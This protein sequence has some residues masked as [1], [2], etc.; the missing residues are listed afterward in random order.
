MEQ[1]I[2]YLG[3]NNP[4]VVPEL[5]IWGIPISLYLFLGG[6]AAGIL[7]F[8]SVLYLRNRDEKQLYS[9]QR[10][11]MLASMALIIGVIA[12]LFD[13]HKI[14]NSWRLYTTFDLGA[15]M[16]WGAWTLLIILP[17]AL[18]WGIP[19]QSKFFMRSRLMNILER[20]VKRFRTPL[21]VIIA[22][23]AIVLAVYTGMLLSAFVA[24]P[25]W[26]SNLLPLIFQRN[27]LCIDH[28]IS[29]QSSRGLMFML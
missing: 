25:L 29:A 13:L 18:L 2:V 4:H 6:L 23:L 1:E 9:Y 8:T 3:K 24:R 5:E 19:Y 22:L 21:A 20:I 10:V 27:Y 26:N 15:P 14:F 11:M 28:S 7:F 12:L 17:L 16:S